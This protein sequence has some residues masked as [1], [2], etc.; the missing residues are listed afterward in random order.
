MILLLKI[1]GSPLTWLAI[2]GGVVFFLH[3]SNQGLHKDIDAQKAVISQLKENTEQLN[4]NII[5]VQHDQQTLN[6]LMVKKSDL[7]RQ[8]A[9]ISAK[10]DA[11]P[12]TSTCKPF[13]NTN[14]LEAARQFREYQNYVPKN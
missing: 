13:D 2:L 7:Q 5:L 14:T 11:I 8:Q 6:S 12:D 1:L 10:L 9:G 3:A 4:R